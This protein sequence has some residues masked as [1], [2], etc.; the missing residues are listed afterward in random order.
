MIQLVPALDAGGAERSA[1]E[2]GRALVAAG[3]RSI[4]VSTGG[5]MVARLVAEGSEH[6]ELPIATQI[7]RH[8]APGRARCA[9]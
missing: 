2:I 4:V 9:R 1:L 7:A 5:R 8:A 3:H 6:I